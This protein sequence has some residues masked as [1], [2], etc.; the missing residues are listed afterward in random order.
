M[1]DWDI[2]E[3]TCKNCKKCAL[4]QTRSNVVFGVG[5]K[6]ADIMFV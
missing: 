3:A 4:C 6:N 1:L 2:L 5:P